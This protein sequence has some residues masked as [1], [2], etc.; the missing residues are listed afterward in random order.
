MGVGCTKVKP[1][2][3][4]GVAQTPLAMKIALF[5][6]LA[7]VSVVPAG[8][9]VFRPAVGHAPGRGVQT[10]VDQRGHGYDRGHGSIY[11]YRGYDHGRSDRSYGY[12]GYYYAPSFGYYPGYSDDYPYYGNS[13]YYGSGSAASNGL[14]LGALAGGIIG[15]NS[16]DFRHN[17]WRGAAWGAGLGWLLGSVADANRRSVIY[18]RA[19]VVLPQAS[20]AAPAQPAVQPAAQP[21]TIINNYYNTP[22]PMSGANGLFGR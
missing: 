16:G 15:N 14:L 6:G 8:A 3:K 1:C 2:V 20:V 19:P 17:G 22:S 13:G 11:V 18:D 5:L 10:S 21:V 12:G 4:G 7:L 9:Q